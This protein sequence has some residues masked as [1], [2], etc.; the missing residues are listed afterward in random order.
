MT[1]F[2]CFCL[3]MMCVPD[4]VSVIIPCASCMMAWAEMAWLFGVIESMVRSRNNSQTV[5]WGQSRLTPLDEP[6]KSLW[7]GPA[8]DRQ[9]AAHLFLSNGSRLAAC[10]GQMSLKTRDIAGQG[11]NIM[12]LSTQTK[13]HSVLIYKRPQSVNLCC[14]VYFGRNIHFVFSIKPDMSVSTDLS[15]LILNLCLVIVLV[16]SYRLLWLPGSV[17]REHPKC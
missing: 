4:V 5:E 11:L 6:Y 16:W 13:I 14:S 1:L 8:A 2:V 10:L 9:D 3:P 7:K 15:F 17:R 12:A